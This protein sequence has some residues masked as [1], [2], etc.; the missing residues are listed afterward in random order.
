MS[1]KREYICL[2]G[3]NP[4]EVKK[5][6]AS[7]CPTCGWEAAEAERRRAYLHECGLTLCADGLRRLIIP[8]NGGNEEMK[9]KVCDH[10]GAHLDN[11]ETCDCRN[12]NNDG[13]EPKDKQKERK[14]IMTGIN[15]VAKQIHENAVD[16]GW[17]DEE[18]GFPEIIALCHSE[19]SEALEEYR[20]G[21]LPTEVY[22]GNN[23][24]PEGIPIELADVIIRVLDYCG[25][26]G[27]DIDAAISQKHEYNKTRP[28]RHGGKKC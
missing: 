22:T 25:Y 18:R 13:G 7:E 21:R 10:C 11:G 19:L 9:Y 17:W 15:E 4:K 23:G 2:L 6:N 5:C 24:K 27:I 20:N 16:H 3:I 12:T 1:E 14:T 26:A 8:K 28:Y